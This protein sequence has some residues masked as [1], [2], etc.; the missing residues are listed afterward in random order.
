[1]STDPT[2]IRL[3]T[4]EQAA[5]ATGLTTRALRHLYSSRRVPVTRLGRRVYFRQSDLSEWLDANTRPA[6]TGGAR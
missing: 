4:L 1:M 5:E 2:P 6:E 3:L